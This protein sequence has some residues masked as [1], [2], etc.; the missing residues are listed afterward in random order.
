MLEGRDL[1]L[2]TSINRYLLP[3]AINIGQR[4]LNR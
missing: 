4:I 3:V 2:M 1:V